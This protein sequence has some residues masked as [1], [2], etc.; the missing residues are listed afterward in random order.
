[1][2]HHLGE[3]VPVKHAS[4]VQLGNFG[5]EIDLLGNVLFIQVVDVK[6]DRQIKLV[7]DR[8][9]VLRDLSTGDALDLFRAHVLA[10]QTKHLPKD[11][12]PCQQPGVDQHLLEQLRLCRANS[13]VDRPKVCGVIGFHSLNQLKRDG[14]L[15]RRRIHEGVVVR[16]DYRELDSRAD[17]VDATNSFDDLD[18][19]KSGKGRVVSDGIVLGL[20]FVLVGGRQLRNAASV[21]NSPANALTTKF[22][23]RILSMRVIESFMDG[24][25][26]AVSTVIHSRLRADDRVVD[27]GGV[28]IE[29]LGVAVHHLNH[30]LVVDPV[31]DQ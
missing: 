18:G 14:R 31:V 22:N 11:R 17:L 23:K 8:R 30:V 21:K 1:M 5:Q 29:A 10:A 2:N 4:R 25:R 19:R 6:L 13:R 27:A 24:V 16:T 20:N 26:D 9:Q 3:L 12:A 28:A 7:M 15:T